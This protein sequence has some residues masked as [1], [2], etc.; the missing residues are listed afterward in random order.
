[1][2]KDKIAKNDK[3]LKITPNSLIKKVEA[4]GKTEITASLF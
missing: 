3:N 4:V 1:M 2:I